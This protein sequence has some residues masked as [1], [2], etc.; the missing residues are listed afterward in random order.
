VGRPLP[1]Q[2][3]HPFTSL[4]PAF[5]T[6]VFFLFLFANETVEQTYLSPS[7][8]TDCSQ[9]EKEDH[10]VSG[11]STKL[12]H[13]QRP[14]QLFFSELLPFA[15]ETTDCLVDVFVNL[16]PDLRIQ[17]FSIHTGCPHLNLGRLTFTGMNH[18]LYFSGTGN[19]EQLCLQG[20][21]PEVADP[22]LLIYST[23]KRDR[24]PLGNF[25]TLHQSDGSAAL[26]LA[27]G[28]DDST[29]VAKLDKVGISLLDQCPIKL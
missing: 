5:S 20:N 26:S 29:F 27:F 4:E 25:L 1:A 9:E 10:K 11:I 23:L 21:M 16:D 15:E 2:Y 24:L 18:R 14:G 19:F 8:N 6:S 12:V 3:L 7:G 28:R 17:G 22:S 13:T